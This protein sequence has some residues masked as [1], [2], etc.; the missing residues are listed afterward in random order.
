M[1]RHGTVLG[2]GVLAPGAN[3]QNAKL[4]L[5]LLL[6]AV[7]FGAIGINVFAAN[8]SF[9]GSASLGTGSATIAACDTD[10][11]SVKYVTEWVSSSTAFQVASVILGSGAGTN[12]TAVINASCSGKTIDGVVLSNNSSIGRVA[13]AVIAGTNVT[14][15]TPLT[16]SL[17][18]RVNSSL[19]DQIVFEVKD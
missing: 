18:T 2:R 1:G 13:S 9:T 15:Q 3:R 19:I 11:F 6:A 4:R 8:I 7:I 16:L 17:S 12:T 14:G 10:G 5:R